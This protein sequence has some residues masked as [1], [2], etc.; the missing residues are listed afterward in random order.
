MDVHH[1][2]SIELQLPYDKA[3]NLCIE[4]LSL[5]KKCK[6][7]KENR[8]QGK[9]IAKAGMTWK[10]WGDVIS[11]DMRKIDNNRTQ[12]TVSSRPIVRTT[13]VDCGKNLENVEKIIR[14]LKGHTETAYNSR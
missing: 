7:Q 8:S 2:R 11:F 4:S 13:L 14:F 6:I 5:I 9:I 12:V 3:F 1:L 10:T